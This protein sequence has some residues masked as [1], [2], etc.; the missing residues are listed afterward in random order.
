MFMFLAQTLYLCCPAMQFKVY[1]EICAMCYFD[2]SVTSKLNCHSYNIFLYHSWAPAVPSTCPYA[3]LLFKQLAYTF[4]Q[5]TFHSHSERTSS[6]EPCSNS[7][8]DM[9]AISYIQLHLNLNTI[10]NSLPQ[11]PQLH[12]NNHMWL[13]PTIFGSTGIEYFY[14]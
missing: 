6:S 2:N 10:K 9:V 8:T 1:P 12:C 7:T 13:V 14:H 5:E 11:L 3:C 4:L